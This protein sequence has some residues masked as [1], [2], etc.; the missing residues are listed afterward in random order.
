MV[1]FGVLVNWL[2]DNFHFDLRKNLLFDCL[3]FFT[4]LYQINIQANSLSF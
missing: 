3:Y 1:G 4:N 2:Q